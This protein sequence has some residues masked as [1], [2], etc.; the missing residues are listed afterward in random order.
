[1]GDRGIIE[2]AE[3][4]GGRVY[5]Y[6]HW[7]GSEVPSLVAKGLLKGRERWDDESYLNRV[8]FDTLT[9]YSGGVTGFGIS[10]WCPDDAYIKVQVN[11]VFKTA[12]VFERN[13]DT[14]W[15]AVGEQLSFEDFATRYNV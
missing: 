13:W 11:H 10:T 9:G 1:M 15:Q 12:Q 5:F 8:L 7:Q 14:N 6:T 4:Q 3:E 2:I